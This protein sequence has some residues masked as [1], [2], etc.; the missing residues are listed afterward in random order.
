MTRGLGALV[1]LIIAVMVI[2]CV[3]R[4]LGITWN[5][6]ESFFRNGVV[7]GLEFLEYFRGAAH[8]PLG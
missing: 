6:V 5:D 4:F 8:T 7:P 1:R 3:E 2:C